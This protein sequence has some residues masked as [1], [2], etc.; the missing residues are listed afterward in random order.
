MTE[1]AVQLVTISP[2]EEGQRLDN[3]L[4]KWAK[5][6]PKSHIY[7]IIRSGEVRINKKRALV[8]SRILS[9]DIIRIPPIRIATPE[10]VPNAH[11]NTLNAIKIDKNLSILHEDD[12]LLIVDKPSGLAVHGGSGISLGLIEALREARPE[13]KFLELVHRLDRD[14]S[15]IL[16]LAKKRLCLTT[17]HKD[18]R[19]GRMDKRYLFVA[20][21][22]FDGGLGHVSLKYPLYKYL[23]PNGERRVKVEDFGQASLTTI[24]W[25]GSSFQGRCFVGEA[26]LKTGRTHQI[27]VHLQHHGYPILG[28]DKYGDRLLDKA[29]GPK[30]LML[31]AHR[32]VI[33]HPQT[34][35]RLTIVCPTPVGFDFDRTLKQELS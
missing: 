32:L 28:D 25:L 7:R 13:L 6:V 1:L 8:T 12:H 21:G 34:K 4:L 19:E 29:I 20:H 22:D 14:T 17:L 24:K 16:M 5:G 23:L 2:E 30:R 26:Q 27:R 10:I 33:T 9:G 18:I 31:H 15:G 3:F 35:E 11:K